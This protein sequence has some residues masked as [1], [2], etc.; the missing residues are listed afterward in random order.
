MA[1]QDDIGL[2]AHLMRR[3]GF[4]ASR[5]ELAGVIAGAMKVR[6]RAP[7]LEN[8]AND[9]L[10]RIPRGPFRNDQISG[11]NPKRPSESHKTDRSARC[12][13]TTNS[14]PAGGRQQ[15]SS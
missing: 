11:H 5:D 8:R 3:A 2:M 10:V 14:Q 4:G 1:H 9:A 12:D 6:L 13:G 15:T 7:A